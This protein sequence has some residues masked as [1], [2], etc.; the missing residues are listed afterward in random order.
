MGK[1]GQNLR[2]KAE[3][4]ETKI[5]PYLKDIAQWTKAGATVAEV[6]GALGIGASTL[7][8]YKASNKELNA[9]FSNGRAQ[10]VINIKAA[11]LKRALGFHYEEIR[12]SRK[13]DPKTGE[14][15]VSTD[16]YKKY[17]IPSESAA[18]MM[19]RNIDP[20]YSDSDQ[21][22]REI[23]AQMFDLKSKVAQE[24]DWV[25]LNPQKQSKIKRVIR[26]R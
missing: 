21:G 13:I 26:C 8:R 11:L 22:V 25:E 19:L 6:A 4:Y 2:K 10:V 12:E 9:A 7:S 3:F 24:R 23:K 17:S 20:E 1:G 16:T 15:M 14:E 18:A 5:K